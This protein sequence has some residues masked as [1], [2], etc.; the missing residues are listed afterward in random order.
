MAWVTRHTKPD[1]HNNISWK[2]RAEI[3]DELDHARDHRLMWEKLYRNARRSTRRS[4]REQREAEGER[5]K[6]EL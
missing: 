5:M 1:K 4:E 3:V 2:V 6:D